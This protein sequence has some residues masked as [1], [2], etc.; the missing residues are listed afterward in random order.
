[1]RL[2]PALSAALALTLATAVAVPPSAAQTVPSETHRLAGQ[3]VTLHLHPFLSDEETAMLRLVASNEQALAVFVIG[4]RRHA[5]IAVAPAEG[6]VRAGV[7]VPSAFAISD[8]RRAADARTGAL[9]GCERAR[10][11]GPACV[12]ILEVAPAR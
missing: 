11:T 7:P 6:F 9:E 2:R 8:L 1:M 4:A 12:V 5:A 3:Q 10:Q